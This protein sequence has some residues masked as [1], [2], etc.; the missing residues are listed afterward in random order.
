[1][2][3]WLVVDM[4]DG[5]ESLWH[6]TNPAADEFG[7]IRFDTDGSTG[8]SAYFEAG[9]LENLARIMLDRYTD[10]TLAD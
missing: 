3:A 9:S 7:A 10:V 5:A 2:P 4:G 8:H 1:M 6:G